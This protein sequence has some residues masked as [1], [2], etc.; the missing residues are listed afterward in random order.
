MHRRCNAAKVS[1][2]NAPANFLHFPLYIRPSTSACISGCCRASRNTEGAAT[3]GQHP[4]LTPASPHAYT[5]IGDA[6]TSLGLIRFSRTSL[7]QARPKQHAR[8]IF[9]FWAH[10]T[11]SDHRPRASGIPKA[12]RRGGSG[13]NRYPLSRSTI[14]SI[15]PSVWTRGQVGSWAERFQTAHRRTK[16]AIYGG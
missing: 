11:E 13:G 16:P 14:R 12:K 7:I 9:P 8:E 15:G 4:L 1:P 10:R 6:G 2:S 3:Q 5:L